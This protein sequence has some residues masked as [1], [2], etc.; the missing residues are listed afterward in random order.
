MH[1]ANHRYNYI[2][3]PDLNKVRNFHLHFCN[4]FQIVFLIPGLI[5]IPFI[6]LASVLDTDKWQLHLVVGYGS[7]VILFSLLLQCTAACFR[8]KA[9][10][11]AVSRIDNIVEPQPRQTGGK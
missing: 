10:L 3:L 9:A 4:F 7:S 8:R 11:N 6:V 5:A 2:L 1:V